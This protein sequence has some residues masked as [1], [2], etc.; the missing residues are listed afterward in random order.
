MKKWTVLCCLVLC[1][2]SLL[3]TPSC[4]PEAPWSTKNVEIT[5]EIV[6]VSAGFAEC[7][8]STNKEAYYLINIEPARPGYDPM[9]HQK[10]FMML[11]LDSVN[12]EYLTWR[13]DLLKSGEI[14]I[15]PF[16]SHSLH[17][18]SVNHFFT[19]LLPDTEY[20]VYAFVVDPEK[21]QPSGKLYLQTIKTTSESIMDV[22]FDYR[23]KGR[24]DYIYPVDSI[25]GIVTRFPYIAITY[26]STEL[27]K[28]DDEAIGYFIYWVYDQ[29]DNP[30]LAKVLYGVKATENDG[31]NGAWFE[32]DHTYY[33]VLA[34][35]DGIFEQ[36]T[37]YKFKWTGDSCE[38]YF[39]DTDSANIYLPYMELWN[40]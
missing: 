3:L 32:E 38:L 30:E 40:E 33:T 18:G 29:F 15:A 12:L 37:V 7:D 2:L 13:N 25:G 21:L 16:A 28:T 26:D 14:N 20:W 9:S 1:P 36:L 4:S 8:F 35:Y 17:Y 19:G 27:Q 11:V 24:W 39:Q 31:W 23:I 5:M 6:N 10:Q 34:G 22:H